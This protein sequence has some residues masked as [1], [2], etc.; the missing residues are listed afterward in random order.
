MDADANALDILIVLHGKWEI[1]SLY[2]CTFCV[3]WLVFNPGTGA[4][5]VQ[6]SKR[7]VAGSKFEKCDGKV[8]HG[9]PE[10]VKVKC[11]ICITINYASKI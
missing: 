7:R 8:S 2:L 11:Y 9:D 1:D 6:L 10:S 4:T 5:R 3:P